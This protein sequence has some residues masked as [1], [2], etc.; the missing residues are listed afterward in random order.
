M[1]FNTMDILYELESSGE[2]TINCLFSELS[3][4]VKKLESNNN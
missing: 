2:I 4:K 3:D 1:K